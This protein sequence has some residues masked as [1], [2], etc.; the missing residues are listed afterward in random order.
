[1]TSV[2]EGYRW[3]FMSTH[4]GS[5]MA[6]PWPLLAIGAAPTLIMLAIGLFYFR[7]VESQFADIV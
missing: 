3:C 2:V 7:R 5:T 4:P 1:M 6:S